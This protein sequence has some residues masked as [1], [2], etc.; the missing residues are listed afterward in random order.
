M[1]LMCNSIND[2]NDYAKNYNCC[3]HVHKLIVHIAILLMLPSKACHREFVE[4][5]R[6][7][8]YRMHECKH[9]E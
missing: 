2:V 6:S 7:R 1:L 5:L 8:H 9:L 3:A 4:Q